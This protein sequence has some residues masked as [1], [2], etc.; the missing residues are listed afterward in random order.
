MNPVNKDVLAVLTAI[1][2]VASIFSTAY[3]LLPTKSNHYVAI[4]L[5]NQDCLIGNYPD[6]VYNGDNITYCIYVDNELDHAALF[7]IRYKISYERRYLPSE[8]EPSPLPAK[9]VWD[10][11]LD[12]GRNITMRLTVPVELDQ[13][14]GTSERA[15]LIFELWQLDPN[16]GGWVYTGRS[17]YIYITVKESPL[18]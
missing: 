15:A 17:V 4:G 16:T 11:L 18:R 13:I 14:N 10:V 9:G 3:I 12:K 7:Q 1:V 2:T 5:L 6:Q 8:S